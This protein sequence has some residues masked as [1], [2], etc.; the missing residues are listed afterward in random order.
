[1]TGDLSLRPPRLDEAEEIAA[2]VNRVSRHL[3]GVGDT[4]ADEVRAWLEAPNADLER[5]RALAV[6]PDGRLAG[7][8]DMTE[9]GERTRYWIDLRF[10]AERGQPA[11][12]SLLLEAM[13][14]RARELALPGAVA[15]VPIPAA[16]DVARE[17]L[18]D[19]GYRLIR[20][21][22][23]MAAELDPPPVA[24]EWPAGV[25]VR[26]F[27][28]EDEERVYEAHMDAFADHWEF[29]RQS[30]EEWSHWH[31]RPPFDPSLWFLATAAEEIAAVCL[32]RPNE[33]GDPDL[34]WVSVLGVR[35]PCCRRGLGLALLRHAFREFARRGKP[36]VGLG[37]DA[38]NTT[39][40][41]RLYERAG[42]R[43]TRRYDAYEKPL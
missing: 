13:E 35:P 29:V 3:H 16:H 6:L 28:R 15:R 2:F 26:A 27:E 38:E 37:V 7:Y 40:A 11:A 30:Y 42:M 31:F 19:R 12:G 8:A 20:H 17:L 34:G 41:V 23:R 32:C 25:A 5:D 4:T 43:I 24:P 21:S 9:D 33:S 18:E 14:R 1:M 36:R 22:L 39:G 10:S